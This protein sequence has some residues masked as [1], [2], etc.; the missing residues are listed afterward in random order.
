M[1]NILERINTGGITL[2]GQEIRHAL[3]PGPVRDFLKDLADS[4]EFLN[5]TQQSM[6]VDRMADREC[7]LR[8]LAF[9]IDRWEQYTANDLNGYLG[10]A[11]G[12]INGMKL[13]QCKNLSADFKKA[14]CAAHDIFDQYAFRRTILCKG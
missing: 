13:N 2:N 6:K 11:M 7:I 4:D 9:H 14:M 12:K 5:A 3:H 1:F 10:R 8:F